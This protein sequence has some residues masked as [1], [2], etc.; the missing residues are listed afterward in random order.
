M[1]SKLYHTC[2]GKIV[3][4]TCE[5]VIESFSYKKNTPSLIDLGYVMGWSMDE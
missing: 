4:L 1:I 3:I 2:V 5:I